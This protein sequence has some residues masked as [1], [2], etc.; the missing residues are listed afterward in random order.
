MPQGFVNLLNAEADRILNDEKL[1]KER[2]WSH[3]LAGNVRKE[4]AIDHSKIKNFPEFLVA[5]SK[6]YYKHTI[7]NEPVEGSKIGFRV[8]VV[9]QYAGDFNP[10]HIHDANL[11]GVAFRKIPPKF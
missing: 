3:N 10:M 1:S 2:D 7:G 4:I 11:S 5:M 8:W 9:S 6:Q